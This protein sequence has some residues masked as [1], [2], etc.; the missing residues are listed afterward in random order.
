LAVLRSDRVNK[1]EAIV[2]RL[3]ASCV[4]LLLMYP[5]FTAAAPV[6]N[7][8][9]KD[10]KPRYVRCVGHDRRVE[11]VALTPDGKLAIS[12]GEDPY[13]IVWDAE[14]GRELRR[15][16]RKR[17]CEETG[18]AL[19]LQLTPDGKKVGALSGNNTVQFWDIATGQPDQ[20]RIRLG[21][22]SISWALS[23]D[24][25]K[26]ARGSFTDLSVRDV[27]R[28]KVLWKKEF[29]PN[30]IGIVSTLSFSPDGT[31]LLAALRDSG[32]PRTSQ[33]TKK[34]QMWDV[35][36]GKELFS[37]WFEVY[38]VTCATFSSDGRSFAAGG[39]RLEVW[40]SASFKSIFS[41]PPKLKSALESPISS[42]CFS[43]TESKLATG[44]SNGSVILWEVT[45]G[46]ELLALH[47]QSKGVL[48]VA[49]SADGAKLASGG[50]DKTVVIWSLGR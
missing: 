20:D 31:R 48:G 21:A 4:L 24:G 1:Q 16:M 17:P 14:T 40:D 3:M 18:P 10:A 28:N 38:L 23:R 36:T 2:K 47:K 39:G 37:A 11:A 7:T 33:S 26:V 30:D 32:G 29:R 50:E 15:I 35:S 19:S 43:P 44:L 42:L 45:S 34:V 25:S 5:S 27:K 22:P 6:S 41:E 12:G 8:G 49:F 46:N 9:A 13:L